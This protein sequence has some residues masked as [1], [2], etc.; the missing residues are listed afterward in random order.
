MA[1][2]ITLFEHEAKPFEWTDRDLVALERLNRAVGVKVV[3][4]TVHG[5]QRKLQAQQ[6]VGVV[7]FCG[8]TVQV[9]P[10]IYRTD[11]DERR[12]AREATHNLLYLLAYAG[13]L[14]V[15]EH[16][17]APLLRR[18][19]DWF[20]ILTHLF[21]S[22]L[23]DEW[24]RGAHRGYQVVENDLPVLKGKWRVA[25]QLRH[26]EQKCSFAV[27]YDEFTADNKL[28]RVFRFV[29][30]RLWHLTRD[31]GN[32]QTLGKLRQRMERVTLLPIVTTADANAALLTRLNQRYEPLLN[33]ARLFLTGGALQLAAGQLTTFAFVFDMNQLFEAFL[34]NFIRR[35]RLQILPPDLQDCELLPQSRGATFYL[36]RTGTTPIFQLRPDLAF[37]QGQGFPLLLDAKYKRLDQADTKLGVSQ[38]DFYQM[39]AY[40]Y[41][42]NC[43]R[44]LLVYPQTAGMPEPLSRRFT[45]ENDN[46]TIV[47]ATVDV[48]AELRLWSEQQKLIEELRRVLG[49]KDD[50][51]Q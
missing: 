36:A 3:H 47:A 20:E 1:E 21:A 10:K 7:R 48:R 23:L 28:N 6:M 18:N 24:Q 46:R 51:W 39:H 22:H 15:R 25:E 14:S 50:L 13:Q 29:V 42:Y 2:T 5:Q 43:P 19:L 17:L 4:A 41:R 37:R 44:V 40:A 26:P 8:H 30:E 49:G 33:L 38:A 45:L 32:R 35:H 34:V 16:T 31:A 12:Q 11:T 9:L 27:A